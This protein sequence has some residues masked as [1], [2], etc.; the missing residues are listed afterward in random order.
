MQSPKKQ[1][2]SICIK[3]TN[4]LRCKVCLKLKPLSEFYKRGD[5]HKG[6][7]LT[8]KECKRPKMLKKWKRCWK[9][10]YGRE[11]EKCFNEYGLGVRTI[12]RYG[13]KLA[14]KI[15]D[16]YGRKCAECGN[17]NSLLIHHLDRKGWNYIAKGLK[18]NDDE[19]NLILLC[20]R[21]HG[22][23]HG[24]QGGRGNKA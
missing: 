14:L 17:K 18:P 4:L 24:K 3:T 8:C 7:R 21:C 12:Q 22:R 6:Y 16:K 20:R 2:G 5:R 9:R 23:I 11:K 10:H 15:Y 1:F 13:F 19:N